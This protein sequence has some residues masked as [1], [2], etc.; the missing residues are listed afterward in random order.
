MS[1]SS[2]LVKHM[3]DQVW[4]AIKQWGKELGLSLPEAIKMLFELQR[5]RENLTAT[6]RTPLASLD[7]V[8]V[9]KD[10]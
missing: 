9:V 1:A 3:D 4:E 7:G 10:V 8:R 5:E 6:E 2:H